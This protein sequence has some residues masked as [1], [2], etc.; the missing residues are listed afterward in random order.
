MDPD[1]VPKIIS[2]ESGSVTLEFRSTYYV[3]DPLEK[4]VAVLSREPQGVLHFDSWIQ[5][6]LQNM[7]RRGICL[8]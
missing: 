2:A 4:R 7:G 5:V 1:T 6:R 3:V 8:Q